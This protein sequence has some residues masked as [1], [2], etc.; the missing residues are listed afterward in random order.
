MSIADICKSRG[1]PAKR[2]QRVKVAGKPGVI[3]SSRSGYLWVL[4]DG[5]K[6]PRACHPTWKFEY[7]VDG[8]FVGFGMEAT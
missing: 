7:E 4:F 8:K 1:V 2:G 6:Y 5:T 3:K